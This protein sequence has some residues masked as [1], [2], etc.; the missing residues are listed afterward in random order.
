MIYPTFDEL[1]AIVKKQ[2]TKNLLRD[3]T[4][5]NFNYSIQT[6]PWGRCVNED[7]LTCRQWKEILH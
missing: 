4:C 5:E 3:K 1:K 2:I 6:G 7:I